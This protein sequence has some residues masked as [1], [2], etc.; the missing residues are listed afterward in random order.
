MNIFATAFSQVSILLDRYFTLLYEQSRRFFFPSLLL[1]VI[2]CIL[3]L[4]LL[5]LSS[6]SG[7]QFF[8]LVISLIFTDLDLK[9]QFLLS[10]FSSSARYHGLIIRKK[11]EEKYRLTLSTSRPPPSPPKKKKNKEAKNRRA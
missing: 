2:R 7:A 11:E 5:F 9:P 4:L 6:L 3:F 8:W 1:D 10:S